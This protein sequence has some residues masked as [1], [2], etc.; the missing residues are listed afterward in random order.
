MKTKQVLFT[1]L[2]ASLI[3]VSCDKENDKTGK[4]IFRGVKS[5]TD[6]KTLRSSKSI[7]LNTT[8]MVTENM[9]VT[10]TEIWVSQ[11]LVVVGKPDDLTWYKIGENN[12]LKFFDEYSFT[13]E[14][15]PVGVYRSIKMNL[16][17]IWYRYAYPQ[18]NPSQKIEMKQT[19]GSDNDPCDD[20]DKL[21][22]TNYFSDGGNHNLVNNVFKLV[23]E[24][25]KVGGFE[26][27]EG[28]LT[29][30]FMKLNGAGGDGVAPCT[31]EWMDINSNGVWNCGIDQLDNFNCPPEVQTMFDF[32]VKYE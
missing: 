7:T 4:L 9:K 23:S 5:V 20:E 13:V 11:G 12:V 30:L 28:K 31:F 15:L 25:E 2:L 10:L 22:P 21:V 1:L 24:G 19:M 8:V 3:L 17:N 32:I 16:K 27:K 18:S 29:I 26:I 14:D 6:Q